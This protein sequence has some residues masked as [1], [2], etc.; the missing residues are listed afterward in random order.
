MEPSQTMG[1]PRT[2]GSSQPLGSP[3]LLGFA[4]SHGQPRT[5]QP[6]QT[7]GSPQVLG[8]PHPMASPNRCGCRTSRTATTHGIAWDRRNPWD[9]R[10]RLSPWI[11]RFWGDRPNQWDRRAQMGSPQPVGDR[12]NPWVVKRAVEDLCDGPRAVKGCPGP[13][14]APTL[15][16]GPLPKLRATTRRRRLSPDRRGERPAP[17]IPRPG[18]DP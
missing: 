10:G 17:L 9:R 14:T 5:M 3:Q 7:M 2:M 13:A 8:S 1:S 11:R 12:H 6:S 4:A 15:A 16:T 18:H